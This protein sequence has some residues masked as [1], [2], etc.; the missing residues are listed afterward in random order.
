MEGNKTR[1]HFFVVVSSVCR[2]A[3]S[4][5][6]IAT[7]LA[8]CAARDNA[9]ALPATS[10]QRTQAATSYRVLYQFSHRAFP[11]TGLI[12]LNGTLYGT[13][14]VGGASGDGI[15]YSV[16][17]GG[18]EKI[19]HAFKGH[20]DGSQPEAGLIDVNG[21][22]YGTTYAGG[23]TGCGEGKG[24]GTV[25]SIST[26]GVEKVL[27][28]FAGG[29][30]GS[31]PV[32]SLVGVKGTLYG[33]TWMGGTGKCSDHG[34]GQGCGTVFSISTSGNEK[35]LYRF[36]GG[37]DGW[38]PK[39]ALIDVEG[40]L[41][42]TTYV[43]GSDAEG[44]VFRITTAGVK[45]VLHGFGAGSDGA[46]PQA[47]LVDVNGTLYGTT[48]YGGEANRGTVFGLR[49]TGAERVLHSFTGSPDG[50]GPSS[51]L[52]NVEGTLFGT[53]V[54]GGASDKGTIYAVTTIGKEDVVHGFAG[55]SKGSNPQAGLADVQGTLYGTTA[56]GGSGHGFGTVYS[57]SP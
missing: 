6:A 53:S 39:A 13:T 9:A 12:D 21:T 46:N 48:Y 26:S 3:I 47:P 45:R 8:G 5:G 38:Y 32:S 51:P 7:M 18:V 40:T 10:E 35:V 27:H 15:V 16:T 23:G 20:S 22:L 37:S 1:G 30:D 42:G 55:G 28:S 44:T 14:P 52:T 4:L 31:Y 36:N 50:A 54:S 57:W 2:Y 33:T 56:Y 34:H 11:D 25:F 49:T 41:Y 24:C 17:T 29:L 19:L 43:G